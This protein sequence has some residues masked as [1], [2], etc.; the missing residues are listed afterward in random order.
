M[1]RV[2]APF[3][4]QAMLVNA[5]SPKPTEKDQVFTETAK[6]LQ[7]FG[8]TR[9]ITETYEP[10]HTMPEGAAGKGEEVW[11]AGPGGRSVIEESP[12]DDFVWLRSWLMGTGIRRIS[13]QLVQQRRS[14]WLHPS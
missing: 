10:N 1:I 9:S 8:G 6:L 3:L 2:L 11:R 13:D 12:L 5:Q 7:T 4:N 14:E